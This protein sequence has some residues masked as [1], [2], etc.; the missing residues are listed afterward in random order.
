MARNT[1][2]KYYGRDH[3]V[4]TGAGS[5]TINNIG[6]DLVQSFTGTDSY[7][8][9]GRLYDAVAGVGA[10]HTSEQQ[11]ARGTCLKGTREEALGDIC[12]WSSDQSSPPICWLSG[13]AGVGKSAIAMT[14]AKSW[15]NDGLVA[16][17]FFFRSDPKRNNFSA[18]VPTIALGLVETIPILRAFVERQISKRPTILDATL[19]DQF[20]ELVLAPSLESRWSGIGQEPVQKVPNLVILDGL[21]ECGDEDAQL[22]IL[23]TI[24]SSYQQPP[25][26]RTP[27]KILICSRPEA[28]LR[29]AFDNDFNQLAQRIVLNNASQTDRD[30]E[31]LFIYEFEAIRTSRKFARLRFPSPWPSNIELGQLVQKSS[32]QFVYAATAMK[33]IKTPY[34]NPHSQLHTI[35]EY[36]PGNQLSDSPFPELDRLYHIILSI[37]PNR[38]RLLSILA[39]IIIRASNLEPCPEF[40]EILLDFPPGEV[41]LMLRPMHSVLDIQGAWDE[42]KVFHTSFR[43]Y[44][45][46]RSRSGIF[47]IDQPAHTCFLARRWLQALSAERLRRYS[48]YQLLQSKLQPFLTKWIPFCVDHCQPSHELLEGLQNVEISAVLLCHKEVD[49]DKIFSNLVSWLQAF[50]DCDL[51]LS[52]I[53]RFKPRC[54]HLES[55]IE[56]HESEEDR[57]RLDGLERAAILRVNSYSYYSPARFRELLEDL[58]LCRS[59]PLVVSDCRCGP[60]ADVVPSTRHSHERYEAACLRTVEA[61]TPSVLPHLTSDSYY[62]AFKLLVDSSLLQHCAFQS[63]L[64]ARCQML[65]SLLDPSSWGGYMSV[66]WIEKCRKRLLDWL[67]TCPQQY[68]GEAADL[69][70]RVISFF[71]SLHQIKEQHMHRV[72]KPNP[73]WAP[74]DPPAVGG[75]HS[76]LEDTSDYTGGRMRVNEGLF[77]P[78]E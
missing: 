37:N 26:I 40:I 77:T 35:L 51:D 76:P 75:T 11:Y 50:T 14:I 20:R 68:T 5:L 1:P 47:F 52:V 28:W 4:N 45:L 3:N 41:D 44:L 54:F 22:R 58:G 16:S 6:G 67:E 8:L 21:D 46:D 23:S 53:D 31:R 74:I 19:E 13:T 17:F 24:L 39:P 73:L 63:G 43:D 70:L 10:S 49:L 18:L 32:S 15:E 56:V 65:F 69:R 2:R 60:D 78:C 71:D 62:Y 33:F 27:L 12:H 36:D 72:K 30:L 57:V 25:S 59:L 9:L 61:L 48:F 66:T 34:A 29:E 7:P 38:E 55:L 42:I 64:I